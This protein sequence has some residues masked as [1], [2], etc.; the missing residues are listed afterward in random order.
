MD[1]SLG[2]GR[3][4]GLFGYR[5]KHQGWQLVAREAGLAS[6]SLKPHLLAGGRAGVGQV[7]RSSKAR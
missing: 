4:H 5:L 6:P 3:S 7:V 1:L 2:D